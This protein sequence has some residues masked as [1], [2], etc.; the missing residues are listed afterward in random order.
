MEGLLSVLRRLYLVELVQI[1]MR[2]QLF[3]VSSGIFLWYPVATDKPVITISPHILHLVTSHL[4]SRRFPEFASQ[5]LQTH[6][7]TSR[8]SAR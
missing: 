4:G 2:P 3:I 7:L 8:G 5:L 1:S 6:L